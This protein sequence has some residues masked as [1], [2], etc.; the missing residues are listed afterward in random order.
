[1]SICEP[2]RKGATLLGEDASAAISWHEEC[3]G[4]TW[5]DCQHQVDHT[6]LREDRQAD[7]RRGG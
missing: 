5:C 4:G 3:P 6:V 7:P 2:C 1:M